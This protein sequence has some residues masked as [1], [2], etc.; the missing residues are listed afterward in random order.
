MTTGV[1]DNVARPAF[2]AIKLCLPVQ[3]SVYSRECI[4]QRIEKIC[5]K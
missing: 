1:F 2:E 5:Y 3:T 4:T